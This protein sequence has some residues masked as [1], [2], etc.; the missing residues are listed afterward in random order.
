MFGYREYKA[1]P[2]LAGIYAQHPDIE[3]I[4]ISVGGGHRESLDFH[5]PCGAF[6][7]TVD[8]DYTRLR[9]EVVFS[10][11]EI[12]SQDC[13][14]SV[15][16]YGEYESVNGYNPRWLDGNDS[17]FELKLAAFLRRGSHSVIDGEVI[18]LFP[19]DEVITPSARMRSWISTGT[20]GERIDLARPEPKFDDGSG[21]GDVI[22]F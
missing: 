3:K 10:N 7:D 8:Y 22:P 15:D 19:R 18:T 11:G 21:M 5:Y 14:Y 17:S 20:S 1:T 13:T 16:Q 4:M 12:D 9:V 6:D 2:F